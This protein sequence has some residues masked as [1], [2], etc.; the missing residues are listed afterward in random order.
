MTLPEERLTDDL[1]EQLL[2]AESPDAY[3]DA[4]E[5]IDR[6]LP[7][8]LYALLD[9]RGFNR[10]RL[11]DM[12]GVT[13]SYVYQIFD[14]LRTPGRDTALR[15]AFGLRCDVTETQRLLRLAGVS[16]LWPKRR[17]D[18]II[19]WC[20]KRGMTYGACDE[21]LARFSERTLY[22]PEGRGA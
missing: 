20:I 4:G 12:S 19:L 3:L 13:T 14:G 22:D 9:D 18:A 11:A 16:E 8:Y 21:E 15:L 6:E 1:L 7:D 5:A 2:A 17:R 10:S